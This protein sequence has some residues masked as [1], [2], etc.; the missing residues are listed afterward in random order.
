M[1]SCRPG[2]IRPR[3]DHSM[4]GRSAGASGPLSRPCCIKAGPLWCSR[5]H[6]EPRRSTSSIRKLRRGGPGGQQ[7]S[8]AAAAQACRRGDSSP[9]QWAAA[10][11]ANRARARRGRAVARRVEA[12][13]LRGPHCPTNGIPAGCADGEGV[14]AAAWAALASMAF[15]PAVRGAVSGRPVV[16]GR[17]SEATLVALAEPGAGAGEDEEEGTTVGRPSP[18]G[19]VASGCPSSDS[20]RCAANGEP[21]GP[22]CPASLRSPATPGNP[23]A[24]ASAVARGSG[25]SAAGGV[26]ARRTAAAELLPP[27]IAARRSPPRARSFSL[28]CRAASARADNI[29][30]YLR[31][32]ARPL[33]RASGR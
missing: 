10:T 26:L 29:L 32:S 11:A 15:P 20:D 3:A 25:S 24:E 14:P 2:S 22:V 4:L 27:V 1:L 6:T 16:V 19:A 13:L 9:L 8:S 18:A 23:T 5:S 28:R 17:S 7:G 31:F 21:T 30:V 12:A 33:L